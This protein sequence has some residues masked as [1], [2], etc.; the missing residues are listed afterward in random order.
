M[1]TGY[2]YDQAFL[3]HET[4]AGHP[5]CSDRLRT[6]LSYLNTLKGFNSLTSI[7]PRS[8]SIDEL[9]LCHSQGYVDRARNACLTSQP[10]LDSMDVSISSDSYDVALLAAGASLSLSDKV[11]DRSID[12][13]MLLARP[14][15]H[16]A[17]RDQAMG[18]CL[19]NNVALLARY[20]QKN[21]GLDKI[22]ILDWDVH[23]GN[24]TQHTFEEDPSVFYISSHEYPYYPGTGAHSE[25]GIGKGRGATLNCPLA[26]GC[27]D[28]EYEDIFRQRILPAI[29]QF[30][31]EF[32]LISAGFDAHKDDPLGHMQISTSFY[33]WM[34]LRIMEL[35][36]KHCQGRIISVLEGGYDLQALA[37]CVSEHLRALSN[38]PEHNWQ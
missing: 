29:D 18:F 25:N 20:L 16:H 35:A 7:S 30:Q 23:H 28:K 8:I 22:C 19:F 12:N 26:A 9:L 11:I 31:P 14:P 4:S 33:G 34:T 17:E 2:I 32:I 38:T 24:G 1:K 6:T 27:G 15:G 21:H 36:D 5:E 13:G 3:R 37:Y 10:Y